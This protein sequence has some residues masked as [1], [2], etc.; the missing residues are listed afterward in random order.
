MHSNKDLRNY[1]FKDRLLEN[2]DFSY[3]DLRGC[4]FNHAKLKSSNFNYV[5][6]GHTAR[7][8][9]LTILSNL[10]ALL[11]I[12]ITGFFILFF[13]ISFLVAIFNINMNSEGILSVTRVMGL[14]L[15]FISP[16]IFYWMGNIVWWGFRLSAVE[17]TLVIL[18]YILWIIF[19]EVVPNLIKQE[20]YTGIVFNIV[21]SFL[22]I[23]ISLK[24]LHLLVQLVIRKTPGTSFINADLSYANFQEAKIYGADFSDAILNWIYWKNSEFSGCNFGASILSNFKVRNLLTS[25]N[26]SGQTYRSLDFRG[27]NLVEVN[28]SEADLTGA[29]LS[30]SNLHNANLQSADLSATQALGADLSESQFTQATLDREWGIDGKT[31]LDEIDCQYIY[32]NPTNINLKKERFPRG[33]KFNPGEFTKFFKKTL[34][35]VELLFSEGVDWAV[36]AHSFRSLQI[37]NEDGRERIKIQSIE[38]KG[39]GVVIVR[40]DIPPT[41]KKSVF[42]DVFWKKYELT[43]Q[44][45]HK[46]LGE[47][48]EALE[49]VRELLKGLPTTITTTIKS[50]IKTAMSNQPKYNF[51]NV[52][53][54]KIFENVENFHEHRYAQEKS[55]PDAAQEIQQLLQQLSVTYPNS[56]DLANHFNQ[57]VC[58][59]NQIQD[60]LLA[61]GIELV[62]IICPPLGIPI[63]MGKKWIETA[64]AAKKSASINPDK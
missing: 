57:E 22:L 18:G 43:M 36:F 56:E 12:V 9:L 51:P 17:M 35:T 1:S 44:D 28:L 63:E 30:H 5:K 41:I 29:N 34:T 38:D 46:V 19:S 16:G 6:T 39:D 23:L 55:L 21:F 26:G 25:R 11:C 61:G 59:S 24:A 54:V 14:I 32:I 50:E 27:L 10:F 8:I 52:N 45:Y 47:N 60:I 4:N 49:D 13:L 33:R 40:V 48:Q 58:K 42:E 37:E 7:Q 2:S 15:L 53:D 64:Q 3:S 31:N 62:K 20:K